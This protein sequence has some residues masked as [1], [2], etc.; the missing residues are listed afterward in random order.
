MRTSPTAA[1]EILLGLPPLHLQ[2]EAEARTG[3][4]CLQCSDQWKPGSNRSGHV[5]ITLDMEK[6]PILQMGSDKMIP[7]YVYEKPFT[8]RFPD[9]GEWEAG[10]SRIEKGD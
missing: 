7:R 4:Y 3:I 5:C 9:R 1:L 8:I 10:F 2:L 6:E